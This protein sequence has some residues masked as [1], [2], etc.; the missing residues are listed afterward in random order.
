MVLILLSLVF[1]S[2]GTFFIMPVR[3]MNPAILC[4]LAVESN[5]MASVVKSLAVEGYSQASVVKSLAVESN[6]LVSMEYIGN[7]K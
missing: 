3:N 7:D 2:F 6:T 5:T 1:G 4:T